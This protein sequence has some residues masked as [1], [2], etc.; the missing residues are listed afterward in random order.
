MIGRIRR[1]LLS[2][3]DKS[4][5]V[6]FAEA[7]QGAGVELISTGGTYNLLSEHNIKAKK[8]SDV[9]G[10]PEILDGRVKT[11]HPYIFGGILARRELSNHVSTLEEHNIPFIDM[12]VVNLYPFEKTAAQRDVRFED[13]IEQIDIGGPSL[14]RAAAKNFKDVVVV[15]DP[16]E[17]DNVIKEMTEDDNTVSEAIRL[18]LARKVFEHT[19]HYDAAIAGYLEKSQKDCNSDEDM[20]PPEIAL[21]F[22]RISTLR[23]GENPHQ[24]AAVYRTP[25]EK[26][27]SVISAEQLQGKEISYNNIN[28][29]EGALEL[30]RAFEEPAVAII[31]HSNPCGVAQAGTLADAYKKALECD[32][33]SAF[34]GIVAANRE[35]D[36]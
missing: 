34:G 7:L 32:P 30:V 29:L 24:K 2:V 31:K 8:V 4:G 9:T 20:F 27:T 12:V 22:E 17:Y 15:C 18:R 10:F 5:L 26:E 16:A 21:K 11:L 19:S 23:Y 35:I 3:S 6:A 14:L 1:A 25:G 13:V 33:V 36:K 28:D